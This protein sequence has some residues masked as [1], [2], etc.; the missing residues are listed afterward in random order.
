MED[1]TS[2]KVK[3]YPRIKRLL[4]RVSPGYRK[5]NA[6]LVMRDKV[7]CH[8]SFWD[9][10]SRTFYAT[11]SPLGERVKSVNTATAPP[12]FG[13]SPE[14]VVIPLSADTVVVSGGTFCGKPAQADIFATPAI[15]AWLLNRC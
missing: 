5:H 13:G 10:G 12:Q 15:M 2:V 3:E 4:A 6:T 11:A 7:T 9:G 8:G 14:P 1:Y